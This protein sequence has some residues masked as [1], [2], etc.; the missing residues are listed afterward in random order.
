MW[1][2]LQPLFNKYDNIVENLK[3]IDKLE[4]YFIN[5]GEYGEVGITKDNCEDMFDRWMQDHDA[6]QLVEIIETL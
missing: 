2:E 1:L 6:V 5:L 3:N 4:E